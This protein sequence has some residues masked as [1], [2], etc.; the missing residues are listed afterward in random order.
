MGGF[1]GSYPFTVTV[2]ADQKALL[3]E[4]ISD[5][6]GLKVKQS[7]NEHKE[8]VLE[9]LNKLQSE[10]TTIEPQEAAGII[11]KAIDELMEIKSAAMTQEIIQIR[12]NLDVELRMFE[13][14]V[15][16]QR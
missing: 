4:I 13:L 1:Y 12:L 16:G 3:K 5:V 2:T 15:E 10:Q 8:E 6:E 14:R 9:L 7:D 11:L